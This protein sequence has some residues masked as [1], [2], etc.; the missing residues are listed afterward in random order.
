[1][2]KTGVATHRTRALGLVLVVLGIAGFL[3]VADDFR[4]VGE[5]LG[6]GSA[7]LAGIV[8]LA[9]GSKLP[10]LDRLALPWIALGILAGEGLGAALDAM[11]LAIGLGASV[12]LI[13][14]IVLGRAGRAPDG[15]SARIIP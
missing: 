1:M 8:L 10:A 7:L 13:L 9:S 6:V 15:R 14:S 5:A 11:P 2:E 12:G 3:T 4:H